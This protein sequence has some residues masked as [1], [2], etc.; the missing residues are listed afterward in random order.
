MQSLAQYA[1]KLAMIGKA[2]AISGQSFM[3]DRAGPRI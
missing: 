1:G 2:V 3:T